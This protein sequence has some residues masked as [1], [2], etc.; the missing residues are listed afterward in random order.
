[1]DKIVYKTFFVLMVIIF[2][3]CELCSIDRVSLGNA[4]IIGKGV[5]F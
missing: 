1:M 4:I 5:T 3:I 2:C